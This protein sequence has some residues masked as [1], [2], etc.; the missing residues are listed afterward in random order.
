MC[1]RYLQSLVFCA[2]KEHGT[3]S[4]IAKRDSFNPFA[5]RSIE[6]NL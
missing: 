3:D 5:R 6:N 4:T 2:A 1:F